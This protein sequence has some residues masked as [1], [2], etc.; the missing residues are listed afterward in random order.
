MAIYFT[1]RLLPELS[2]LSNEERRVHMKRVWRKPLIS[3]RFWAAVLWVGAMVL[4]VCFFFDDAILTSVARRHPVIAIL[5]VFALIG[6]SLA[7]ALVLVHI[8]HAL[9]RP[10]LRAEIGLCGRCGYDLRASR[11]RCPECGQVISARSVVAK[12]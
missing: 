10:F 9:L 12:V 6:F 4:F 1:S 11:D 7:S 2:L 5:V 3:W 8:Y